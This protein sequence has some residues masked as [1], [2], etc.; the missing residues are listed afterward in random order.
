MSGGHQSIQQNRLLLS[1][2]LKWVE[3]VRLKGAVICSDSA[4]VLETLEKRN[5]GA[6]PD[7]VIKLLILVY[8]IQKVWSVSWVS[9]G[10]CPRGGS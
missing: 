6:R 4:S 10:T 2:P 9:L 1:G 5:L 7:I 8:R 3:E